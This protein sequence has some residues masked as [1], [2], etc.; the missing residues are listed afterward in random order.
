MTGRAAT[1]SSRVVRTSLS[2]AISPCSSLTCSPS[3]SAAASP[4]GSGWSASTMT[5]SSVTAAHNCS[6]SPVNRPIAVSMVTSSPPRQL[7]VEVAHQLIRGGQSTVD[8]AANCADQE[9][10]RYD[11]WIGIVRQP[12]SGFFDH[13]LVPRLEEDHLAQRLVTQ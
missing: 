8:R 6:T 10:L 7:A 3:T 13:P 1:A 4:P 9:S 12:H 5:A 11:A 2:A